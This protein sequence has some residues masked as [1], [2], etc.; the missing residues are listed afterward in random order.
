MPNYDKCEIVCRIKNIIRVAFPLVI[1]GLVF[2][3]QSLTDKAFLGNLDTRYV[4]AIGAAQ[5]PYHTTVDS[6]VALSVGLIIV[7]AQLFGA[8]EK[9]RINQYVK[10]FA[11]YS[12]LIGL[13]LFLLWQL[14][15]KPILA[16]FNID[17]T[18]IS[19][20]ITYIKICSIY[21]IFIGIDNAFQGMLQGIGKTKPIMYAGI[22]KVILNVLLSYILIFG[23]FGISPM[24]VTGAAIGTIVANMISFIFIVYYCLIY[25]SKQFQL[26]MKS[27]DWFYFEPYKK[28]VLLGIPVGLEYLLWNCSNLVLIRFI[29]GFSYLNMAI[30][31]V[32]FGFQCIV[33]V[34]FEGI[35]RAAL[36]LMGQ[37]LGAGE[38]EQADK[39]FFTSIAINFVIVASAAAVFAM[40]PGELLNIF[41]NDKQVITN[42]V[43]YLV[44]I[45]IIMFP[46]SMNVICGNGIK[47]NNDTKWM[48]F[49]QIIGSVLVVTLSYLFVVVFHFDMKTIYLTLFLDE[50]IRG[51]I[52]FL[53]YRKKYTFKRIA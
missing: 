14:F 41:S 19:Y 49:S 9:D 16:F 32:T 4:S 50:T 43:F 47:A 33:Y 45:G 48:L 12:T 42:G 27:L 31:T 15:T 1:Q 6:L 17:P 8:K 3:I 52:N 11:F 53:Y 28:V 39:Y 36:T 51:T 2:Q 30:Y 20:S 22:L 25:R 34:V 29:N 23:K 44:F 5:M 40:I 37:S 10:S 7:V 24:Y 35:S 26:K 46:Q 13:V 21:M 38:Q 18:I